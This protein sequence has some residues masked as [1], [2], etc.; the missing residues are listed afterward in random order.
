MLTNVKDKDQ[1]HDRQGAVCT[2]CQATYIGET[3]RNLNIRL[4]EHKWATKNGDIRNHISEH[5]RLTKHKIDWDSAECVPYSTNY[6]QRL[7]L[8]SWYT[9]SEKEP[10]NRCQQLPAPYKRLIHYLKRNQPTNNRWIY[11]KQS[12]NI[13]PITTNSTFQEP[14][15]L[16]QNVPIRTETR[17]INTII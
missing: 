9:N 1:P 10:T 4:I 8:E 11:R 17:G 15:R 13:R 2:D 12:N 14:I 3:D 7:T 6:Q 16:R 5:H